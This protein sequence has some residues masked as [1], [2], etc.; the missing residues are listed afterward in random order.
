MAAISTVNRKIVLNSRPVG[1]TTSENFRLE[2][3]EI[4][5]PLSWPGSE[6]GRAHV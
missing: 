4:P 5:L 6:I 2:E 1:A 3:S